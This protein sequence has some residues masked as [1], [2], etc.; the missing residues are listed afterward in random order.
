MAFDQLLWKLEP[1][2]LK[3][4][5]ENRRAYKYK[6]TILET[7]WNLKRNTINRILFK[8][9][10]KHKLTVYPHLFEKLSK[11]KCARAESQVKIGGEVGTNLL[12]M[13]YISRTLIDT[14]EVSLVTKWQTKPEIL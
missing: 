6:C 2:K 4:R 12:L 10:E 11:P 13:F 1:R 5:Q 14:F 7:R 8:I 3:K 9:K